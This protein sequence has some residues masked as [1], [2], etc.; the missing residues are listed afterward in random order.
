MADSEDMP[1]VITL[2]EDAMSD[3]TS[4]C[5]VNMGLTEWKGS[6]DWSQV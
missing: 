6:M 2:L 5:R 3:L 4:T 1:V